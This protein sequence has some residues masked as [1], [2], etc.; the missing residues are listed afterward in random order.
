MTPPPAPAAAV[1]L[2]DQREKPLVAQQSFFSAKAHF[3]HF[4]EYGAVTKRGGVRVDE[5]EEQI[6]RSRTSAERVERVAAR[7]K[8]GELLLLEVSFRRTRIVIPERH[9]DDLFACGNVRRARAFRL[10]AHPLGNQPPGKFIDLRIRIDS[11][12]AQELFELPEAVRQHL[13]LQLRKPF[14]RARLLQIGV[15]K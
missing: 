10:R 11:R 14:Q 7:F 8:R 12:R 3:D 6:V 15:S 5:K 4:F 1:W 9:A 13:L 2:V